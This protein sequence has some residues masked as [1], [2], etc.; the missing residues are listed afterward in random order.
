MLNGRQALRSNQRKCEGHISAVSQGRDQ[1]A[2][3]STVLEESWQ[4]CGP[5]H[6]SLVFG[7]LLHLE[8]HHHAIVVLHEVSS[9]KISEC[10]ASGE[11]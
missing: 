2:K 9:C 1:G 7:L 4:Q 11:T 3:R 5:R 10:D 8:I 6:L